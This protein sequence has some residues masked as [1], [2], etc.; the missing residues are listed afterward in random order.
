M[1]RAVSMRGV[2]AKITRRGI[3]HGST[4][5]KGDPRPAHLV[6]SRRC[7][8]AVNVADTQ[9]GGVVAALLLPPD[10]A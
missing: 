7:A 5:C 4:G 3:K 10:F 1:R 2:A 9:A 8:V 6:C